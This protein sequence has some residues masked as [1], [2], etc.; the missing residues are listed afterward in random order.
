VTLV[1]FWGAVGLVVY[2]YMGFPVLLWLRA[3]LFAR[4][5]LEADMTPSVSLVICAHN[6]AA[7]IVRKLQN[8]LSLDYPRE[9]LQVVIASDGS[10]DGTD[11][12]V[13]AFDDPRV[14]LL[15]LPRSGKIAALNPAVGASR[16]EVLV[17]SDANSMFESDAIRVLVRPLA[18]PAV[19]GVAG[20][21]RYLPKSGA[22]D[23]SEGERA[24]WD[25]DR[26]LK[27]WQSRAG[28]VTS[29]TGA[30]YAIRRDLFRWVPAGITDDFAVS[31]GVVAQG[32]RL[33]YAR[34]AVAWEEAAPRGAEFRRKVRILTRG[35]RG[36]WIRRELLNPFRHGFYA[37]QLFSHKVLRRLVAVPFLVVLLVSPLLWSEGLV[38]RLA[39]V[40][41]VL[42]YG[43]ACLGAVT[44]GRG[45][46]LT[47][48]ELPLYFC[49]VNLAALVAFQRALRGRVVD[50]WEPS[51]SPA[52]A[53][54]RVR[55]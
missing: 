22:R 49:S 38:Y 18:D 34:D 2:T 33:V 35:L 16:G 23:G 51:R 8:V 55:Q 45:R 14:E 3:R 30:I 4:P 1:L 53:S 12:L 43:T 29:A 37:L 27:D 39:L 25:L 52:G 42:L 41:Q 48:L 50:I 47:V 36:V 10:D 46:R 28:S 5:H 19:G 40:G 31:T 17:F 54:E 11:S 26:W 7:V 20:D 9:C 44:A 21:Q 13:R 15:S 6:E 32:Y 24:Y